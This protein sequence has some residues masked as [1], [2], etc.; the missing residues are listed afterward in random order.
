MTVSIPFVRAQWSGS[1]YPEHVVPCYKSQIKKKWRPKP[2]G[3]KCRHCDQ[4][5]SS[6]FL[7]VTHEAKAHVGMKFTCE[8]CGYATAHKHMMNDHKLTHETGALVFCQICGKKLRQH[9]LRKHIR[10]VHEGKT[11]DANCNICG[12]EFKR[13]Y[14]LKAHMNLIHDAKVILCPVCGKRFGLKKDLNEHMK[15][16]SEG[17]FACKVCGKMMKKRK[18]LLAHERT[19]TGEK[20]FQ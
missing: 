7:R 19:H 3:I 18:T 2:E 13:S 10:Y 12:E 5:F 17:S 15:S 16:H 14:Q 1:D 9:N 20:P 8:I 11:D 6:H 4:H